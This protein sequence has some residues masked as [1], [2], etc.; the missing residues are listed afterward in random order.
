MGMNMD[1][2]TPE[3]TAKGVDG[4]QLLSLDSDKLK[5]KKKVISQNLA[6]ARQPLTAILWPDWYKL[7]ITAVPKSYFTFLQHVEKIHV[8]KRKS[9]DKIKGLYII[10][11][12]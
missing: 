7:A 2:Y 3:F 11:H 4:Q 10:L 12:L 6:G 1:Q 5:V 8:K 9:Q